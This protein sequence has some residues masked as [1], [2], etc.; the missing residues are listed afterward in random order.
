M[1]SAVIQLLLQ[2]E[3]SGHQ[4]SAL[5]QC[6]KTQAAIEALK[7]ETVS[8]KQYGLFES[9][10]FSSKYSPHLCTVTGILIAPNL[11]IHSNLSESAHI[12]KVVYPISARCFLRTGL[13]KKRSRTTTLV[14]CFVRCS[15]ASPSRRMFPPC[16]VFVCVSKV[17]LALDVISK[18]AV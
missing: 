1:L 13:L 16:N 6:C 11:S 9:S 15:R 18:L 3:A 4:I 17:P 8:P 12:K 14:P 2:P 5:S 7:Q 10:S